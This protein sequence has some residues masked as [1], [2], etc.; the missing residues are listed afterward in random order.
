MIDTQCDD[1]LWDAGRAVDPPDILPPAPKGPRGAGAKP[2]VLWRYKMVKREGGGPKGEP[3]L[4][5][6]AMWGLL[7]AHESGLVAP[8][9]V[10]E[11]AARAWREGGHDAADTLSVLSICA[12]LSGK[13]WKK[14]PEVLKAVER[15][16]AEKRT[17]PKEVYG[18]KVAMLHFG[19]EVS[20]IDV[21]AFLA[22]QKPDGSWGDVEATC[23]GVLMLN[24]PRRPCLCCSLGA[25]PRR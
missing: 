11:R 5:R 16:K 20:P 18:L 23:Y 8:A 3:E 10:V 13:D 21:K 17:S 2:P 4:G 15:L 12:Y 19:A 14:D 9:E 6:W 7:A 25:G 22:A 24:S 1:G